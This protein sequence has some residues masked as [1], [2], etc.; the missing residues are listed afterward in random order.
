M[1]SARLLSGVCRQEQAL[2]CKKAVS[3]GKHCQWM[4]WK[5]T[6]KRTLSWKELNGG[7][8]SQWS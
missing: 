3:Q 6:E 5:E 4:Q 8:S 7:I 1:F 2:G